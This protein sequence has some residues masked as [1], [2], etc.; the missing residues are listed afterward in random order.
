[1]VGWSW[2][3]RLWEDHSFYRRLTYLEIL[4]AISKPWLSRVAAL[5]HLWTVANASRAISDAGDGIEFDRIAR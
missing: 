1:M 5:R 4:D 2:K 3:C